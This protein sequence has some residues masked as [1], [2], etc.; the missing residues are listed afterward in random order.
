MV[1]LLRVPVT[2]ALA[3]PRDDELAP[4]DVGPVDH[5][6]VVTQPGPGLVRA[7]HVLERDRVRSG[8]QAGKIELRQLAHVVDDGPQ[9][10]L[11]AFKLLLLKVKTREP[12]DVFDFFPGDHGA[13]DYSRKKGRPG[14]APERRKESFEWETLALL[15]GSG[16]L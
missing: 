7:Q 6:V 2:T 11:E 16:T 13:G 1:A 5:G 4:F 8:L 12:G 10:G 14:Q 3:Y 15:I 9:F